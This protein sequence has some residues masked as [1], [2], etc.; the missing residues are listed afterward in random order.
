MCASASKTT[1]WAIPSYQ[2]R[3]SSPGK[4]EG[5]VRFPTNLHGVRRSR[6][7][8]SKRDRSLRLGFSLLQSA[9]KYNSTTIYRA[10]KSATDSFFLEGVLYI[11]RIGHVF[12][13]ISTRMTLEWQQRWSGRIAACLV[14]RRDAYAFAPTSSV[15]GVNGS[16]WSNQVAVGSWSCL[17]HR[18]LCLLHRTSCLLHRTSCLL[19][20]MFCLPQCRSHRVRC[21]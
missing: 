17:L 2:R 18:T 3:P 5:N 21:L 8:S 7:H 1:A 16:W 10:V 13:S 14:Y 4:R 12:I 9:L 11:K 19:H 6:D 15:S 20:R